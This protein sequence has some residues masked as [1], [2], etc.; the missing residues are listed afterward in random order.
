[1]KDITE[2]KKKILK[3]LKDEPKFNSKII[4]DLVPLFFSLAIMQI[5]I[6]LM[7]DLINEK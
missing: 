4:T 1:M 2:L 3:G 6:P 5:G 7:S